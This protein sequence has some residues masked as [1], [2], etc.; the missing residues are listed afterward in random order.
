[1]EACKEIENDYDYK[2]E[3]EGGLR[4]RITNPYLID[5]IDRANEKVNEE[6]RRYSAMGFCKRYLKANM[7]D[8]DSFK[9]LNSAS[10]QFNTGI[11][12]YSATNSFGGRI[13]ETYKCFEPK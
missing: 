11:I 9:V 10:S 6:N 5:K 3:R 4:S 2:L 7:K 12:R 1:M 8:P 13:Q